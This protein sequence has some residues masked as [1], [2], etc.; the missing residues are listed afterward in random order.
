MS[1]LYI[2]NIVHCHYY[3]R[4]SSIFSV[5]VIPACGR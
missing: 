5:L 3:L 4:F 1:L 2:V